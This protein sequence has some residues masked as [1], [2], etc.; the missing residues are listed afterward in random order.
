MK[1]IIDAETWLY[2]AAASN[3]YEVEFQPDKWTYETNISA[4]KVAFSQEMDRI[5][6][7]APDHSMVQVLGDRT[8]FRYAVYTDYKSNRRKLRK[9]AGYSA[10]RDWVEAS[11]PTTKLKNV[12]ADDGCGVIYE[13]GDIICSRDKDLRTIPGI[14]LV[15]D[16][17]VDVGKFEADLTFYIQTLTGDTTDGY[18][19]LKGCG[20]KT[21]AKLLAGCMDERAMWAA[22][23]EAYLDAGYAP[24]Y[25]LQMARCARILR[26]GEYDYEN[27]RAILW[28]PPES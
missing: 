9:P 11:W 26:A 22:V 12:E 3:E 28:N 15:G 20:P 2:R 8:N 17:I 21:A 4:A 10:L 14:H 5:Q 23:L 6:K 13:E 16:Q 25:P 19:G 1:L 7:V 27:E 18:P 24:G